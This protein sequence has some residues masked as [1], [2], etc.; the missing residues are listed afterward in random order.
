M[1]APPVLDPKATGLDVG[2][3]HIHASIGGDAPRV[4]G[5]VTSQLHALRDRLQAEGV[6]AVAMEATGIWWLCVYAVLEEAGLENGWVQE[7]A[8]ASSD[9]TPEF[10]LRGV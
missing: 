10:N 3:E 1:Q 5:T 4:F 7:L 6:R 8:A 2:S 9:Y